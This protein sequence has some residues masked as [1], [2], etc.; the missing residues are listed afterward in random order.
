MRNHD[1][2]ANLAL[3]LIS[4]QQFFKKTRHPA[5]HHHCGGR[6]FSL[7]IET[8]HQALRRKTFHEF[9]FRLIFHSSKMLLWAEL[10]YLS[11]PWL[12]AKQAPTGPEKD[13]KPGCR[14][15]KQLPPNF[16]ELFRLTG[17]AGAS[18]LIS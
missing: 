6:Q 10:K 13:I 14:T 5:I 12:H 4:L 17:R 11:A 15:S 18:T 2:V 3:D 16:G 7:V 1:Y 8:Y 9:G